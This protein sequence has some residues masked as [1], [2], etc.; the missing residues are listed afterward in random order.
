M[1]LY[2]QI[3]RMIY[4][5]GF[6]LAFPIILLRLLWRSR[7]N[8]HYRHRWNERFGYIKRLPVGQKS[9]WVHAV[10]VGESMAA[11]PLIQELKKRYPNLTIVVTNTTPTGSAQI[12]KVFN[13][14]ILHFYTPFDV[15][16]AI[17][18]FIRR[19]NPELCIIMET[20]MWPNLLRC[21]R[22]QKITVMLANARLSERSKKNYRYI[23][24]ITRNMLSTYAVVS[25]QG[26]LDGERFIELGLDP[27][28]LILSGNIKFDI[29]LPA[30]IEIQAKALRQQW[31]TTHRPTFI[32]ASTHEG[33]ESILLEAFAHIR[34]KI[35]NTLLIIVPRHPG[36]F[37][38]V[39]KLC[40][41]AGY[42]IAYRSKN[43]TPGAET[44]II[45]GDTMG[46][47]CL[48]YATSD[49]AF[50]GGSLVPT[51]GHNLIE[52]A[53]LALPV[54][55]GPYLHN[56]IEI[57]KLLKSAGAAQVVHDSKELAVAVIA[58]FSANELREKMGHCAREV[59]IDNRGALEK[60]LDWISTQLV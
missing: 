23:S 38:R 28:K 13:D 6:Y 2:I 58:L 27:R 52:P 39:A 21:L 10:S 37:E 34:Q 44:D 35:P 53:A 40:V 19:I 26:L 42:R 12:K 25:A 17:N 14:E 7:K 31:G 47:L 60:H 59:V 15:S 22:R 20:E 36:R 46:E 4:T 48:I 30:D 41:S 8:S 54:L 9:I 45:L 49:V 43:E 57:S 3:L 55:T 5:L 32:A 24:N 29:T 1:E 18:R 16:S 33:E 50:V 51:G 56:F 11:V